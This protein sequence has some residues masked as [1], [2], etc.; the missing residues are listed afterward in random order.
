[1][2]IARP[3][4]R[5]APACSTVGSGSV[6]S[7][8]TSDTARARSREV[9]IRTPIS[10]MPATAPASAPSRGLS[11]RSTAAATDVSASAETVCTSIRPMRPAAPTIAIGMVSAFD[12]TFVLDVMSSVDSGSRV[13]LAKGFHGRGV[14]GCEWHDAPWIRER[15]DGFILEIR[16]PKLETC[17][18]LVDPKGSLAGQV[19]RPSKNSLTESNH[20]VALGSCVL[21]LSRIDSSSSFKQLLLAPAQVHRRLHRH[22]A[23]E[24]PGSGAARGPDPL[25]P[26][27]GTV[28]RSAFP[29]G[30]SD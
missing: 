11:S 24:V 26:E 14:R 21:R 9:S 16:I 1:M 17:T 10:P 29:A 4:D 20:D 7:M 12:A 8:Q 25:S 6:K 18:H 23:D 15:Q 22:L 5:H 19:L 30:P 28:V 2:T 27:A 3:C 13:N